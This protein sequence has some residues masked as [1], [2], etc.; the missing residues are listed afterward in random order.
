[1]YNKKEKKRTLKIN[2]KMKKKTLRHPPPQVIA[3]KM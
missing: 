3:K 2:R 1:M